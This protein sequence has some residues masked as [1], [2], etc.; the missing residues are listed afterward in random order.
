MW[1]LIV[2]ILALVAVMVYAFVV[3]PSITG[4]VVNQQNLGYNVGY[5]QAL[6]DLVNQVGQA[7]FVQIPVGANQSVI[8]RALT[9][10]ELA[11]LQQQVQQ[12]AQ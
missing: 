8:L 3:R 7:G 10:Q 9:Q 12:P 2:I 11:Q 1:I 6:S 5:N 4:Y